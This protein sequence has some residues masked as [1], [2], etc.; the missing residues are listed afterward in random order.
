MTKKEVRDRMV[1]LIFMTE[2]GRY[3]NKKTGEMITLA[4]LPETESFKKVKGELA[5]KKI[6]RTSVYKAIESKG[7]WM[8]SKEEFEPHLKAMHDFCYTYLDK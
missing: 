5:E 7:F 2:T 1:A 8:M 3:K 6:S 4:T